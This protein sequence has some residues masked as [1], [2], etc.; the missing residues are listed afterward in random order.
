[1]D[2]KRLIAIAVTV[3]FVVATGAYVIPRLPILIYGI[4][5]GPL[6][7]DTVEVNAELTSYSKD[8][9]KKLVALDYEDPSSIEEYLTLVESARGELITAL[10]KYS[11]F[12]S[13]LE[14]L[15]VPTEAES[16]QKSLLSFSDYYTEHLSRA[17]A[18]LSTCKKLADLADRL[19]Y[20]N[21]SEENKPETLDEAIELMKKS[22]DLI[23][24][25][26]SEH[27]D[28]DWPLEFAEEKKRLNANLDEQAALINEI[29]TAL[30]QSDIA[31]LTSIPDR[32][33]ALAKTSKKLSR[34]LAELAERDIQTYGPK[35]LRMLKKIQRETRR[36]EEKYG[37]F[38]T[39]EV[40]KIK[41][42]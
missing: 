9:N 34:D 21:S 40:P 38:W 26:K 39:P 28:L 13:D 5:V 1:M 6:L 33:Q 30:E 18:I 35:E 16:F 19:Q 36:L 4:E 2:R 3:L 12:L 29:I 8:W 31:R 41:S 25:V 10:M 22:H 17:R 23:V 32:A 20:M 14:K 24:K 7:R 15:G 11:I 37:V 42:I 27:N